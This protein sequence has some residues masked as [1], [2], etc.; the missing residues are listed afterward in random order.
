MAHYIDKDALVAEIEG[1]ENIYKECPTRNPYEE[2]LRVGRLIGYKDA[3]Y[4]INSLEVKE[5]QLP[6]PR[7]PHLNNIVDKVFGTGNLESWEYKEAEQLVLLA[8]EELLKDLEVKEVDLKDCD[9]MKCKI[10]DSDISCNCTSCSVHTTCKYFNPEKESNVK[11]CFGG[12]PM[13]LKNRKEQSIVSKE[14]DLESEMD[15]YFETMEVLEHENI[16]EYTF[17]RIAKHFFELGV[18]ARQG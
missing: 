5:S 18:K 10:D 16:F 6:N 8:K 14:V 9:A 17:Q 13:Q 1:L 3:L 7:F 12:V 11:H 4:K 2:G 15:T